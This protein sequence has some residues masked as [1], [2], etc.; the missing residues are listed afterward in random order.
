MTNAA[1]AD[2][3][4][5]PDSHRVLSSNGG[6]A[7]RYADALFTRICGQWGI[8]RRDFKGRG[9][10]GRPNAQHPGGSLVRTAALVEFVRNI[11][12]HQAARDVDV[13][14]LAAIMNV[15]P[16]TVKRY[17]AAVRFH[18][19]VA[20]ATSSP[21]R[22][23]PGPAACQENSTQPGPRLTGYDRAAFEELVQGG[24]Q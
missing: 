21:H 22:A 10:V 6:D 19:G 2:S 24:G 5:S 7:G 14:T 20:A 1:N 23:T 15:T 17:L 16:R 4:Q 12:G 3:Q 11:A 9:A 18:L 13:T 8:S